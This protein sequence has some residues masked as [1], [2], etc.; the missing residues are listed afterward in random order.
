VTDRA[1]IGA[2]EARIRPHV[3][4]TPVVEVERELLG[5]PEPVVLKLELL[6]HAGSF[7]P[8]GA[9]N[10]VLGGPAVPESGLVAASGGNHGVAV[11]HVARSLGLRAQVFVPA[12][13]PL[14][15]RER[16]AANGAE[17]VVAGDIYDDA[18]LAATARADATGALLVHPYDHPDVVAGQGTVGLELAEQAPDADTVLV[19]V[20]GG[21]LIAGVAAWFGSSVKV[22][23]VEPVTIPA[24]HAALAAGRP[25]EVPVSG[26]AAD[27]LGA[28]RIGDVPWQCVDGVVRESVLVSDDDIRAA[29]RR[30]FEQLRLVVE[31]G[32]AAATAALLSRAYRPAPG[33][34]VVAIVCGGNCDP[35]S[36]TAP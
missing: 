21:G 17:V 4:R 3:R 6:Q 36:I 30:L 16:I 19:A 11:A 18:Q 13:S 22:V 29:Q 32:G 15:K 20:G 34:R 33:E 9:F 7:K 28:K 31:P 35:A 14:T 23:S 12:T 1:A 2:A 24:L 5:T 27:S 26:L 25:V 8:R 10:R